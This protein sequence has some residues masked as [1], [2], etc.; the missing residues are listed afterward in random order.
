MPAHLLSYLARL[1]VIV[2]IG[3]S[4]GFTTQDVQAQ[5]LQDQVR[6]LKRDVEDLQRQVFAGQPP[7]NSASSTPPTP[8]VGPATQIRVQAIEEQLQRL[9]GT[10]EELQFKL[11]NTADRVEALS[12]DIDLRFSDIT[13]RLDVLEQGAASAVPTDGA[14]T[15]T[16]QPAPVP[17]TDNSG[18]EDGTVQTLGTF[19]VPS[20]VSA[21]E[22]PTDPDASYRRAY[23]LVIAGQYDRAEQELSRFLDVFPDN[24][25]APN[26]QYWLAETHYARKQYDQAA[27]EFAAGLQT[28]PDGSKAPDNLL[29]LG[30]SLSA[31]GEKDKA[32]IALGEINVRHP[33]AAPRILEAAGSEQRKLAC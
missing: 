7:Q 33:N 31:M 17:Q 20:A 18:T 27:R 21:D 32:C 25:K 23:G 9:T 1:S 24:N 2:V 28:Y 14:A 13:A 10:I 19:T 11:N 3:L 26:A 5:G 29:K 22:L 15:A 16:A 8:T 12:G 4:V 6:Q 30:L